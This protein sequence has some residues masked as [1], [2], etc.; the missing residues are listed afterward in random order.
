MIRR[1]MARQPAGSPVQRALLEQ[2]EYD[3]VQ[4]CA[5]DGA[6]QIACPL[7]IDTGALIKGFRAEEHTAA[8]QRQ[9][10]GCGPALG[11]R[12]AHRTRPGCAPV[13]WRGR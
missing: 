12:R 9:A 11:R 6:C 1:E 8:A 2:Y 10:A 5:A 7:G 3:G 4:T 13:R